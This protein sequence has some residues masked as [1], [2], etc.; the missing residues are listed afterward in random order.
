MTVDGVAVAGLPG[1]TFSN[2]GDYTILAYGDPAA[3]QVT[4]FV[5]SNLP[6]SSGAAYLRTVNAAVGGGITLSDDYVPIN[7]DVQYGSASTYSPASASGSSLIQITSPVAS[8][9]TCTAEEFNIASSGVYTI[10]ILGT[11]TAPVVSFA[12]DR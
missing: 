1:A 11:T 7:V 12:R 5:D 6:S 8:F 2:G 9:P 3:P 4:V 10:F